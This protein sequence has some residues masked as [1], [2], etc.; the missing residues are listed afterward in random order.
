MEIVKD[1]EELEEELEETEE[2]EETEEAGEGEDESEFELDEDGNIIIPEEAE[3]EPEDGDEEAE[4]DPDEEAEEAEEAEEEPEKK[5]DAPDAPPEPDE[6]D[7]RIAELEAK[8]EKISKNGKA[9]LRKLGIDGDEEILDGI[10]RLAAESEGKNLEDYRKERKEAEENEQA[11]AFVR[12]QA[13]ENLKKADLAALHAA[14]PD[15]ADLDDIEKME[16]FRRFGELRDKGLSVKEAYAAANPEAVRQSAAEAAK[17]N[18][19]KGTKAHIGSVVPKGANGDS[20]DMSPKQMK[21]WREMFPDKT[22]KEIISLFKRA[23]S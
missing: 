17:K 3:E 8:L 14:Y 19:L 5:D 2:T 23:N 7:R 16:N 22:K 11:K 21:E 10:E 6:K 20:A 15:T 18:S 1:T 13:Y 9:A 4:E 12:K